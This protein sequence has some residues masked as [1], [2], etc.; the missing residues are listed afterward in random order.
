M[1]RPVGAVLHE[2]QVAFLNAVLAELA[3]ARVLE[4]APGPARLSA[5]VRRLPFAV[6]MDFSPRML[7]VAQRR[8]RERRR[9]EWSFVRGDGFALP[10][11]SGRFDVV[12]TIRFV[13]RF[14]LAAR[15]KLYAEIRRVLR[16]GGHLVLDA[17]NR[18]VAGPHR[19]GRK[20]YEVYDELWL[21]DELV[22]ELTAAGLP[23]VRLEGIMRR[24]AWQWQFQRLHRFGLDPLARAAIRLL[25]RGSDR[26]PSTW[27]VLCRAADG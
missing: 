13:R 3:P 19:E 17:Q 27:M 25:E 11:A 21:R 16:P 23:P 4:L 9:D 8:M 22:D 5:D 1:S 24:F 14:E 18:L 6:G 15:R 26:N 10:F 2:R 7:G 20:G 12:F